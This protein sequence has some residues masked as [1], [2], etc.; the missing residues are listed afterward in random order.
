M[1]SLSCKTK[2]EQYPIATQNNEKSRKQAKN[3]QIVLPIREADY[4]QF[5]ENKSF[6]RERLNNQLAL[7]PELFPAGM[8]NRYVL[9]STTRK[10]S[11]QGLRLRQAIVGGQTYRIHL[12]FE[13]PYVQGRTD[14]VWKGL[15]LLR[16]AAPF[17]GC[18][19][20]ALPQSH[21]L[22]AA[23]HRAVRQQPGGDDRQEPWK[24]AQGTSTI[25]TPA[26]AR[27]T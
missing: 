26:K 16:Y 2:N 21:V 4:P 14:D 1:Q 19:P 15:L 3:R 9:N 23:V 24:D 25:Q 18:R 17:W 8:A 6:V 13:L 22:V 10:Y 5:I 20:L 12:S 7:H 11:K 27:H